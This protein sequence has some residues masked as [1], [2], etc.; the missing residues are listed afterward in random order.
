MQRSCISGFVVLSTAVVEVVDACLEFLNLKNSEFEEISVSRYLKLRR[1]KLE[2]NINI[3]TSR[4]EEISIRINI[5]LEKS[6]CE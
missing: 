2:R 1:Y 5:R 4:F 3:K 6:Q